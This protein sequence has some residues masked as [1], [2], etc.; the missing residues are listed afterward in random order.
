M[1][2]NT[3]QPYDADGAW[4]ASGQTIERLLDTLLAHPFF[5]A[6]PPK[7]CGREQFNIDWLESSL[8][9]RRRAE[10]VQRTLL[11]LTAASVAAAITRWCGLPDELVVCGGGAHN[12]SLMKRLQE[13]L[14]QTGVLTS[15]LLGIEPDWVEA[16]AFAWLAR[17]TLL[18]R[19]GNLPAVT[20][21]RG[22][23][24]LGAIYPG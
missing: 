13:Y 11:E 9:G 24:V 23:R 5:A 16:M 4:A 15:D 14:P 3:G 2:R 17:Q 19:A 22:A 6:A 1:Q 7:S 8:D 21:A 12:H 18:G 20:G 10:D